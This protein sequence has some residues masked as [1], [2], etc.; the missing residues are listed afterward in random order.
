ML[1]VAVLGMIAIGTFGAALDQRLGQMS[2]SQEARELVR[3]EIPK[4]AEAEVPPSIAGEQR[5]ILQ[6][7]FNESFVHSFR[8]VTLLAAALALASAACGWLFIDQERQRA[9]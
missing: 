2:M 5:N 3:A 7:A 9:H 8:I 4:L 1:A 6:Q